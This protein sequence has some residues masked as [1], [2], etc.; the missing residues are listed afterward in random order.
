MALCRTDS[1]ESHT[2]AVGHRADPVQP[3]AGLQLSEPMEANQAHHE[4]GKAESV[5][6]GD[7]GGGVQGL[8]VDVSKTRGAG[9]VHD[10]S[11]GAAG[12]NSLFDYGPGAGSPKVPPISKGARLVAAAVNFGLTAYATLTVACVKLLHCVQVPGV[13]SHSS[14]T[15]VV[16]RRFMHGTAS[17]NYTGWQGGALAVVVLLAVGTVG[18]LGGAVL[19][20]RSLASS[21]MEHGWRQSVRRGVRLALVD[22]YHGRDG[23]YC[24]ETVLMLQ[25][26]VGASTVQ[27]S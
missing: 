6:E 21:E 27:R 25:R 9:D 22:M 7:R 20:R 14:V 18:V 2:H 26:L 16:N 3:E 23:R 13:S 10:A 24:W 17:C 11:A 4:W 1:G 12:T 8:V 5:D 19:S 15:T